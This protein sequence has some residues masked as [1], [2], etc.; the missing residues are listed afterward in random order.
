MS[1]SMFMDDDNS[2]HSGN[3][4]DVV[5]RRRMLSQDTEEF[6]EGT[7]QDHQLR[8]FGGF[9]NFAVVDASASEQSE[10]VRQQMKMVLKN[11]LSCKTYGTGHRGDELAQ[12]AFAGQKARRKRYRRSG[13][14][15]PPLGWH[16]WKL[17]GLI[18]GWNQGGG[19][20]RNLAGLELDD[21]EEDGHAAHDDAQ[22]ALYSSD[23]D[24][25]KDKDVEGSFSPLRARDRQLRQVAHFGIFPGKA[26]QAS[27]F[28]AVSQSATLSVIPPVASD[29]LPSDSENAHQV[30]CWLRSKQTEALR[31]PTKGMP[32]WQRP[33]AG[34]QHEEW[35]KNFNA[36]RKHLR[37]GKRPVK[38]CQTAPGLVRRPRSCS[39]SSFSSRSSGA[40]SGLVQEPL[41]DRQAKF[42]RGIM[43]PRDFAAVLEEILPNIRS[44]LEGKA[45]SLE[46]GLGIPLQLI[47]SAAVL[48]DLDSLALLRGLP[49]DQLEATV[50]E[51][52]V[53]LEEL[54]AK[55]HKGPKA[56]A[57]ASEPAEAIASEP[58][59]LPSGTESSRLRPPRRKSRMPSDG[60]A[61]AS[62]KGEAVFQERYLQEEVEKVFSGVDLL[63]QLEEDAL[64]RRRNSAAQGGKQ[65]MRAGSTISL[66]LGDLTVAGSA[67]SKNRS[68]QLPKSPSLRRGKQQ[69]KPKQTEAATAAATEAATETVQKPKLDPSGLPLVASAVERSLTVTSSS[70]AIGNLQQG[71][72]EE[73]SPA[74]RRRRVSGEIRFGPTVLG[75]TLFSPNEFCEGQFD[76]QGKAHGSQSERDRLVSSQLEVH[77]SNAPMSRALAHAEA[78][79]AS[80][81]KEA[82]GEAKTLD[83]LPTVCNTLDEDA[84]PSVP[85]AKQ[86]AQT[87]TPSMRKSDDESRQL[88]DEWNRL[89]PEKVR[90]L[91]LTPSQETPN[92]LRTMAQV[93]SSVDLR[94]GAEQG[95]SIFAE[96]HRSTGN[97]HTPNAGQRQSRGSSRDVNQKS[98]IQML[99]EE[100]L[101]ING[102]PAERD[103][104]HTRGRRPRHP[105]LQG[106]EDEDVARMLQRSG[107][108]EGSSL[109]A[110]MHGANSREPSHEASS[111]ERVQ[112]GRDMDYAAFRQ[113]RELWKQWKS[114]MSAAGAST[115]TAENPGAHEQLSSTVLQQEQAAMVK[116]GVVE[117]DDSVVEA[118]VEKDHLTPDA[119][120][121]VQQL[122]EGSASMSKDEFALQLQQIWVSRLQQDSE[123]CEA[124]E[125]PETQTEQTQTLV[126][127]TD[128]SENSP[129]ECPKALKSPQERASIIDLK[130]PEDDGRTVSTS[131]EPPLSRKTSRS[132]ERSP[133]QRIST[134]K[135][136][137]LSRKTS[138]SRERSPGNGFEQNQRNRGDS[139]E[140][141]KEKKQGKQRKRAED[142]PVAAQR[143]SEWAQ[144]HQDLTD[145]FN[146]QDAILNKYLSNF[147]DQ[148]LDTL[149]H[150]LSRPGTSASLRRPGSRTS[151]PS[152]RQGMNRQLVAP[153]PQDGLQDFGWPTFGAI[154]SE[155][156]SGTAPVASASTALP[157]LP[158]TAGF[159]RG[160]SNIGAT[161]GSTGESWR[162]AF[163]SR[164]ESPRWMQYST[165][166]QDA[167]GV[168]PPPMSAPH[169]ARE[170]T[171]GSNI[172]LPKRS[173]TAAGAMTARAKLRSGDSSRL[174][175]LNERRPV[176]AGVGPPDR[177]PQESKLQL[178]Q[179]FQG[180]LQGGSLSLALAC[181]HLEKQ[182]H[183]EERRACE[184]RLEAYAQKV[185]TQG[186]GQTQ[187]KKTDSKISHGSSPLMTSRRRFQAK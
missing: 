135:E 107:V 114:S 118:G 102:V 153:S 65:I 136:L 99:G 175:Q 49:R 57:A 35:K 92:G 148:D 184:N 112:H 123:T 45:R 7:K 122:E 130:F 120:V 134:S 151:R 78:E 71:H 179:Q 43:L 142:P 171:S 87:A 31:A 32:E 129:S 154:P 79:S 173:G 113:H 54:Y 48:E 164:A 19:A 18:H 9:G 42:R 91:L 182:Q 86:R 80:P 141:R 100:M 167:K 98:E 125:D 60:F 124:N 172:S 59:A 64:R 62:Q 73:N 180:P 81:P 140:R 10:E 131:Q 27:T 20:R 104:K 74:C 33:L 152:T 76:V 168:A 110:L 156:K 145:K 159:N 108:S 89:S 69:R 161:A 128:A 5:V 144:L 28:T 181:S 138:R 29:C 174:P 72:G 23:S 61:E 51:M 13:D 132:R 88:I 166:L 117:A 105:S 55:L 176:P 101:V 97:L 109:R 17:D 52:L 111:S 157:S 2:S 185:P 50:A 94:F 3:D 93:S 58:E 84:S 11:A 68:A 47:I 75:P 16:S 56:Q 34:P 177:L 24:F 21:F 155:T 170:G 143:R 38:R 186:T 119:E 85:A 158:G 22:Q 162:R 63:A 163:T 137:P 26:S 82:L 95:W 149:L 14:E 15:E 67:A 165:Y 83:T 150:D 103:Y 44:S 106:E 139:L 146:K 41:G 133:G 4:D 77:G 96:R 39:Q 121:D 1:S 178:Q 25:F 12:R 169:T 70:I 46:E 147:E 115:T 187:W 90:E 66:E 183:V 160:P 30:D 53:E 40:E 8:T 36:S 6:S 126:S 127:K 116:T 37:T